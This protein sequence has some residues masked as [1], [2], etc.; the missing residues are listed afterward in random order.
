MF[1]SRTQAKT[2]GRIEAGNRSSNFPEIVV[3]K[4]GFKIL[5]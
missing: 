2:M 3:P 1:V 5:C 4:M